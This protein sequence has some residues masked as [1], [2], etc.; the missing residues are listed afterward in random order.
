MAMTNDKWARYVAMGRNRQ[1][2]QA[3]ADRRNEQTNEK[4]KASKNKTV[5]I[6]ESGNTLT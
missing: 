1:T 3:K 2:K 6:N 5:F 4:P